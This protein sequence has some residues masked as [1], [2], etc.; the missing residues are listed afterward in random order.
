MLNGARTR[1]SVGGCELSGPELADVGE[2]WSAAMRA[3]DFEAAWRQTDRIERPR[4]RSSPRL[5]REK[6][7]LLWDGAGFQGRDVLVRCQHGLGDTIQYA[8]YF[9]LLGKLARSVTVLAQPHLLGLLRGMEGV[10]VLLDAWTENPDPPSDVEI[11]CMEFPYAFRHTQET[12]PRR[13][14]YLPTAALHARTKAH[15]APSELRVGIVWAAS[16][17][18]ESRSIPL[19]MLESIGSEDGLR[20]FSLQ[21][22]PE[23]AQVAEVAFQVDTLSSS[24]TEIADAAAAMLELDCIV[25]VDTMAAHLA[26]ALGAPVWLLLAC[27]ADWRWMSGRGDSPWYP[28]MRILRQPTPGDWASVV[29]EL[30]SELIGRRNREIP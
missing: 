29:R 6:H 26:G 13:I 9:P 2:R 7:Q 1:D 22:G 5:P 12:I 14:P 21:Q 10:D 11:E 28:T 24:T 25:S 15:P 16:A 23:Q 17:W 8:R 4:R 19:S 30:R 27:Q 18:D 20:L 3:G